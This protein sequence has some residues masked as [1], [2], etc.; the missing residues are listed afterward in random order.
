M[1]R[2]T[3]I[4]LCVVLSLA[5]SSALFAQGER[6]DPKMHEKMFFEMMGPINDQ[7][8]ATND[9][10]VV[11]LIG[12]TLTKFDSQLNT[13]KTIKLKIPEPPPHI[14]EKMKQ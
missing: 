13:T 5:V 6:N 2:T 7:L 1:K 9:G 12:D 3:F 10:G 14:K 8:V 11:L 4:V